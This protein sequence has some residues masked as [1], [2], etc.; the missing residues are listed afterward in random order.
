MNAGIT[1][2]RKGFWHS[3]DEMKWALC[4]KEWNDLKK[5]Y[6][7]LFLAF[8]LLLTLLCAC[9]QQSEQ[10]ASSGAEPTRSPVTQGIGKPRP[11]KTKEI[12][13]TELYSE[14]GSGISDGF[15]YNYSFHVP[16]IEDDTAGA[17]AINQE[18]ASTYGEAAKECLES[19]HNKEIPYC[20]NVEYESF[21]SGEI[22]SLVLKYAYF[23]DGFEEYT[24]YI[25][26][27]AEGVR[28]T[29]EDM[30]KRQ[31]ITEAADWGLIWWHRE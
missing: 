6:T 25:Y 4:R 10:P 18:I 28:L 8:A 15:Q 22:L 1:S 9:G 20:S 16:Q 13:I 3:S 2:G 26:D 14:E 31:N 7:T 30:L 21:H 24:V 23:Y 12:S 27:T 5:R 17:A 19:I 29:N 11:E